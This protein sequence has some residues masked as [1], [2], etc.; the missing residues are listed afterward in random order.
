MFSVDVVRAMGEELIDLKSVGALVVQRSSALASLEILKNL[1]NITGHPDAL[2][3][4]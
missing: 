1:R 4:G 2:K 3:D